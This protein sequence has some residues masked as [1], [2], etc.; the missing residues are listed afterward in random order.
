V[1]P[2]HPAIVRLSFKNSAVMPSSRIPRLKFHVKDRLQSA[3]GATESPAEETL[4]ECG[5]RPNKE[6]F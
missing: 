1:S 2:W 4:Q 6:I 3:F 5:K